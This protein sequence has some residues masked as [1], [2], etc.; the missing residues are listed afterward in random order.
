MDKHPIGD[1]LDT[2]MQK[3]REMVDVNTIIGAPVVTADGITIIPVSKV[4]FGFVSGGSDF[5]KQ[6][7]KDTN[8]GCGTGAGV[9][10]S[11]VAFLV[12]KDGAVKLV[13]ILPPASTTVDRLVELVP[14]VLDKIKE[15][16]DKDKK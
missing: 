10:M 5:S 11:P 8:F 14:E 3:I 16:V 9:T 2:T 15:M 4:S 13:N 12:I 6:T 1:F 7:A